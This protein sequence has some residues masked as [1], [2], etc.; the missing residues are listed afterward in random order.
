[1]KTVQTI[2]RIVN[3]NGKSDIDM[4]REEALRIFE[5][6]R[7]QLLFPTALRP[8]PKRSTKQKRPSR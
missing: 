7:V 6:L 3:S 4:T 2:Y 1:M 8:A 5:E